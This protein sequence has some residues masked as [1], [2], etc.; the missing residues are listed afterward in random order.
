ML[1]VGVS[2]LLLMKLFGSLFFSGGM[3]SSSG[4]YSE[5]T[6]VRYML[7]AYYISNRFDV[8]ENNSQG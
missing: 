7:V 1:T 5:W 3:S 8:F 6:F 2:L 4:K